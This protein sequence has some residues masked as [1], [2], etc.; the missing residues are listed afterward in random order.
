[1][2]IEGR[3]TPSSSNRSERLLRQPFA[4]EGLVGLIGRELDRE[5]VDGTSSASPP[6]PIKRWCRHRP[7]VALAR[8]RPPSLQR[9]SV[10][11]TLPRQAHGG[12]SE[13]EPRRSANT[14]LVPPK[15]NAARHAHPWPTG[16][17]KRRRA[18]PLA[19]SGGL[20]RERTPDNSGRRELKNKGGLQI[21]SC[22]TRMRVGNAPRASTDRRSDRG[23]HRASQWTF[24]SE[25][26]A[27]RFGQMGEA[28]PVV[29]HRLARTERASRSTL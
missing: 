1:M 16:A 17:H 15:M 14:H 10:V 13:H 12:L 26:D 11:S 23:V 21:P 22:E 5:H 4:Q 24:H 25:T 18:D 28:A 29:Y 2:I 27:V 7:T 19:E 6:A 3:H 20:V 8:A 9:A